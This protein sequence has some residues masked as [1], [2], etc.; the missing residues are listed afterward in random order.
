M[1]GGREIR[2]KEKKNMNNEIF[3]F[4][5]VENKIK[6][7]KLISIN[8]KLRRHLLVILFSILTF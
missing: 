1:L 2:R 7:K 5:L 3:L 6:E 4:Y 8:K